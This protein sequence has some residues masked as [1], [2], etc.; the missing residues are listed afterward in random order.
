MNK[1]QPSVP[2][3]KGLIM[4]R[5]P[6]HGVM[7]P[8]ITGSMATGLPSHRLLGHKAVWV[9]VLL[10]SNLYQIHREVNQLLSDPPAASAGAK[11]R[12][13]LRQQKSKL[14]SRQSGA[15][16]TVT[17]SSAAPGLSWS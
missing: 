7:P 15:T 9:V 14:K 3:N 4:S 17:L 5:N 11:E 1:D 13:R 2:A 16:A 6:T 8:G 12:R 10:V